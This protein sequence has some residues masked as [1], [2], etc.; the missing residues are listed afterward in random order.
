MFPV[1]GYLYFL[2]LIDVFSRHIYVE[3]L[4]KKD[5]PT[6]GLALEKIFAIIE[7]KNTKIQQFQTDQGDQPLS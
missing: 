3:P 1:N 5:G 2:L 4:K 7:E 6:V